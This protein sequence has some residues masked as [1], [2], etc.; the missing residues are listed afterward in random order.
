LLSKKQRAILFSKKR[1]MA[2]A[3]RSAGRRSI[4]KRTE[5]R[6]DVKEELDIGRSTKRKNLDRDWKKP[7]KNHDKE[8]RPF[9]IISWDTCSP[10]NDENLL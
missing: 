1:L 10:H 7:K 6:V 5:L 4:A 8:K 3:Q 2:A 9:Y